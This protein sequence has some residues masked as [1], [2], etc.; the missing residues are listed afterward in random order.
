MGYDAGSTSIEGIST[1]IRHKILGACM[2]LNVS[3]W[4]IQS[5]L[6]FINSHSNARGH[7][8]TLP[9]PD[10]IQF[11]NQWIVDGG[12]TSHFTGHHTD[13]IT[14][15]EIPPKLVKGMNLNAIGIGQVKISVKAVSK[16]DNTT[17]NCSITLHNVLY[18]QLS[19]RGESVTRFLSQR[20]A[21]RVE[22]NNN[23]I[24]INSRHYSV[25]DMGKASFISR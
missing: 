23:P 14:I 6:N 13:F 17:H 1:A 8:S 24:F 18:V 22:G 3:K 11:P 19:K 10:I 15:R 20:A 7:Y 25:I 5:S 9:A 4:L 21:H 12:A 2:D 16:S